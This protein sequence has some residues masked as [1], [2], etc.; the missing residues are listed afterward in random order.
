MSDRE[1]GAAPLTQTL[2]R[3]VS[4][5]QM[6]E[7]LQGAQAYRPEAFDR[8]YDIYAQSIFRYIYHRVGDREMAEDLTGEAFLRL[9]ENIGNY[10]I[11]AQ[12]QKAIFSG[13]FFRIAHNLMIDHL[14]RQ[15]K[16]TDMVVE[17]H[18][19]PDDSPTR[20]MEQTLAENRL[21]AALAQ[22]TQDQQDVI[23][24]RFFEELSNAEVADMLGRTEGA[25]KALQHRALAAL[26]RALAGEASA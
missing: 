13:W 4:E 7:L 23:I 24:L 18:P 9:M 15:S 8:L 21:H 3:A 11:G 22:L 20:V 26:N 6:I 2:T 14:R 5:E 12:D 17:T 19:S 10:R 25:I 1:S 16:H